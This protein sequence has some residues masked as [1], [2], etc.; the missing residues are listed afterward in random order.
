MFKF[1][2]NVWFA[3]RRESRF[4]ATTPRGKKDIFSLIALVVVLGAA[5]AAVLTIGSIL[6]PIVS[7]SPGEEG[8]PDHVRGERD[9][10]PVN[11]N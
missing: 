2:A 4:G 7:A 8:N 11:P 10:P 5:T 1:S 3:W 6:P 9:R